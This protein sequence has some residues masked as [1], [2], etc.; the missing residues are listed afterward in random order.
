M[1]RLQK[2]SLSLVGLLTLIFFILIPLYYL[3]PIFFKPMLQKNEAAIVVDISKLRSA[4][5]YTNF[6][7]AKNLIQSPRWF[8]KIIEFKNYSKKLQ[9]GIYKIY[10]GETAYHFTKRVVRGDVLKGQF[11][12]IPGTTFTQVMEK[13]QQSQYI[14]PNSTIDSFN[15][16]FHNNEGAFLAETYVY[17]AGAKVSDLLTMAHQNL[18]DYLNKAWQNRNIEVPWKSPYEL[19][20]AASIIEKEAANPQERRLIAGVMLN[21]IKK[22][23]R[24]QMD[25]TVIYALQE[26]YQGKLHKEDLKIDSPYNTYF[27]KG[28]P[29]TPIAM[30]SKDSIDAASRPSNTEYLYFVAKGDNTH[31]FSKTYDEQKKAINMYR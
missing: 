25:P 7:K 24:L 15:N 3:Y 23:M 18:V 30:V 17:N 13:L 20:I 8:L 5:A 12:I 22:N 1:E 26:K 11:V 21:R 29:P 16:S 9:S 19:L 27:Y 28:L 10:P 2:F 6:L 14:D 31:H 4:S